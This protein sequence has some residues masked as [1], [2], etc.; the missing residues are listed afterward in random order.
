MKNRKSSKTCKKQVKHQLKTE[1]S[2]LKSKVFEDLFREAPSPRSPPYLNSRLRLRELELEKDIKSRINLQRHP[3][4][5]HLDYKGWRSRTNNDHISYLDTLFAKQLLKQFND[6]S[7]SVN[8]SKAS[9]Q[10]LSKHMESFLNPSKT[11]RVASRK[12]TEIPT[13][14]AKL[15]LAEEVSLKLFNRV[16]IRNQQ[17]DE[18][19]A[20]LDQIRLSVKKLK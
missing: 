2:H 17:V 14:Q 3:E 12:S 9:L 11:I 10:S 18:A 8:T 7:S 4:L 6:S 15:K 19:A 16:N 20:K 1:R 13:I 5:V